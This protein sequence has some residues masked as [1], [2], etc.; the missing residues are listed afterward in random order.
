MGLYQLQSWVCPLARTGMQVIK[1]L[2]AL[3]GNLH[4]PQEHDAAVILEFT[5]FSPRDCANSWCYTLHLLICSN[6]HY[7]CS[8]RAPHA[9]MM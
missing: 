4:H 7:N 6:A 2:E 9:L 1:S 5:E 8:P 3:Y